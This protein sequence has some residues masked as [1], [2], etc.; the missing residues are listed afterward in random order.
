MLHHFARSCHSTYEIT[1]NTG[2]AQSAVVRKLKKYG[3]T[4]S[5]ASS[6]E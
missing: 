5:R 2:L 4:V 6:G 3:I 1:R